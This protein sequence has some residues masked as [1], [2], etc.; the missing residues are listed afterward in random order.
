MGNQLKELLE[1]IDF[2]D[3]KR[4]IKRSFPVWMIL[5]ARGLMS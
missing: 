4:E 1:P 2:D 3:A 5:L